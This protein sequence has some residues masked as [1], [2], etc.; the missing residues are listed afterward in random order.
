[1][2]PKK[3]HYCWFG[4]NPLPKSA[5]KCINSWKKYC[6]DY[7]IIEWNEQNFDINS[8]AYTQ[9]CYSDKKY[10]FLSDYARLLIIK[11]YGGIYLD[12]D[13]ELIKSLD[14]L[15]ENSAFFGFEN[16]EL[17]ATGLGFGAEPKNILIDEMLKIYDSFLWHEVQYIPCPIL[18]TDA[19][20]NFG[21]VQNGRYQNLTHGVVYPIDYFN[22]YD[23]P[24][25]KLTITSNTYSIH[26]YSKSW[27]SFG[28][29]LRS[30]MTRPFHRIFGNDCFKFLKKKS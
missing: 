12:T 15:L 22:P 27:L 11:Q 24:T 25:G 13:V 17:I 30:K 21:L 28:D 6:P 19:L 2:I 4:G 26:W 3:I 8:N 29:I 14:P 5:I 20:L 16:D 10:A 18:N 7:E 9:K 1:M 23:N